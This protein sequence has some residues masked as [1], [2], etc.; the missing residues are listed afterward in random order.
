MATINKVELINRLALQDIFADKSKKQIKEFIED[1][2][3]TIA[4]EVVAG[5][6]VKIPGFG[7]FENFTR[8]NGVK[9]PKFRPASQFK[10]AVVA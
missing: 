8:S 1:F 3:A 7:K 2:F 6:D 10:K 5:N 9:T 4:E